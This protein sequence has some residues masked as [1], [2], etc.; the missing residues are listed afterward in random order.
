MAVIKLTIAVANLTNVMS[1]FDKIQVWRSEDG[2]SGTYFEITGASAA[3]AT[4][5]GTETSSFTLNGLTLKLKVDEGS[6]QTITFVSADPINVD[7]V[8]TFINDNLTGATATEDSGAVRLSSDT[9]GTSSTL[10]ITGGTALTELGFVQDDKDNGEDARITLSAGVETY[11]F[12]DQS[13]DPEFYYKVRYYNSSTDAVSD[14]GAASK[15]DV[16]SVLPSSDLIKA[17]VRLTGMDGK[18]VTDRKVVFFNKYVPPLVISE[19]LMADREITIITDQ[20]GYAET[21]LVKGSEVVVTIAGTSIVRHITVPSS[22]TEFSVNDAI[23]AADD[24]FQIQVPDIP[25][26]VRRTL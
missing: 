9:T 1:L 24:L 21:M 26:A 5:L 18:P 12:D 20:V 19:Y 16:G 13:G 3:A 22:G 15:G 23:A 8:V 11:Y 14:F 7:D 6:E 17:I 2:E 10:E 4:I 25:A